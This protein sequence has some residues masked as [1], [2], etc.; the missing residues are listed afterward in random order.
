MV[1]VIYGYITTLTSTRYHSA[2][3]GGTFVTLPKGK[4]ALRVRLKL[5][6]SPQDSEQ[7]FEQFQ[8]STGGRS[9]KFLPP[10]SRT[11]RPTFRKYCDSSDF[12]NPQPS[13]SFLFFLRY[14]NFSTFAKW[15]LLNYEKFQVILQL[16]DNI[17]FHLHASLLLDS[18]L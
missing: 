18:D 4:G 10:N 17:F 12:R 7:A 2:P 13:Y 16:G 15:I 11:K 3:E 14:E 8:P 5:N 1:L 9:I 6:I